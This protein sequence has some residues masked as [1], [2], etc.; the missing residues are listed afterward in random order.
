MRAPQP[1][2]TI[3][4]LREFTAGGEF[5]VIPYCHADYAWTHHRRWH[6]DRYALVI[7]EVLDLCQVDPGFRFCVD[8]FTDFIAPF[9]ARRPDR[10][11]ELWRRVR[12]G[13][14]GVLAPTLVSPRPATCPNE[15]FIRNLTL[16]LRA[17]PHREAHN[18]YPVM[19][20]PDVGFGHSQLPQILAL[21]GFRLYRGWRCDP[22]FSARGVPREFRWQGLDGSRILASRGTYAGLTSVD[23]LSGAWEQAAAR[24]S[25]WDPKAVEL[26]AARVW[27]LPQGMDDARPLREP[28][29]D[30]P[31]PMAEFIRQWNERE[32]S[33]V[34]MATPEEYLERL[35]LGELPTHVGVVDQVDVSY[36]PGW[37]GN[38]GLWPLRERLE[39]ALLLAETLCALADQAPRSHEALTAL[40]TD[41]LAV[42]SHSQQWVFE[43]DWQALHAVARSTLRE[44]EAVI[45]EALLGLYGEPV[46]AAPGERP[47]V[48]FN[49]LPYPRSETVALPWAHVELDRMGIE[50]VDAES[51][52]AVPLQLGEQCGETW[53]GRLAEPTLVFRADVPAMGARRY[54]V[55]SLSEASPREG[56]P[57]I[58]PPLEEVRSRAIGRVRFLEMGP[59]PLSI[60]PIIAV[61]EEQM[62]SEEWVEAG[63]LRW[64]HKRHTKLGPHR[65]IQDAIGYAEGHCVDLRTRVYCAG[66]NGHFVLE[67]PAPPGSRMHADIPFG[68]EERDVSREP[69]ASEMPPSFDNI[70]RHREGGFW[71]RSWVSLWDG[72]GSL[73]LIAE[74]GDRSWIH[75]SERGAV[76][77]ILFTALSEASGS[78]DA[79]EAWCTKDRLALGWHSFDHRVVLADGDWRQADIVGEA[80]RLHHPLREAPPY[81]RDSRR[82]GELAIEPATVRLSAF[83]SVPGAEVL[84]V[85][86][87]CG[88]ATSAR[89]TLPRDYAYAT[90]VNLHG[91]PLGP[92]TELEGG[93]LAVEL[94]AW[95]IA[96]W[97]LGRA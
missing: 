1:E 50:L 84:R 48:L 25:G 55:R 9:I 56:E 17:F 19:S 35:E 30:A 77:H 3:D 94:R 22:A 64:V 36:N 14:I 61:F 21:A 44:A 32:P 59:G 5:L 6:E 4:D 71:A 92:T 81:P 67:M 10:A 86:E 43:R 82:P 37:H 58:P 46:P 18:G 80:E 41:A 34:R 45:D 20:C 23:V 57:P 93:R 78:W 53:G 89:V 8:A 29:T 95:E 65:L 85:A 11:E 88:E 26:S 13:Q 39:R 42:M 54:R 51:G 38:R 79:W 24:L 33:A 87:S 69:Y 16:G 28:G 75:D 62:E 90:P 49:P 96:T 31:L 91:E 83:Y 60:G 74:N 27:W 2:R 68:V 72:R 52:E 15:T 63:P 70:E 7:E 12:Q 40:W 66:G 47:L 73:S 76:G 97:R